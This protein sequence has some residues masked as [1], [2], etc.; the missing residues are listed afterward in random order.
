MQFKG[1]RYKQIPNCYAQQGHTSPFGEWVS[2][3]VQWSKGLCPQSGHGD[4]SINLKEKVLQTY[5]MCIRN[6]SLRD[7]PG[8]P[9]AKILHPQCR[10]LGLDPWSGNKIPHAAIKDPS[11][12]D[13]DQRF[14]MPQLR[15]GTAK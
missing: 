2:E 12:C 9:V 11:C 1:M 7:F 15:P 3:R 4:R 10:G 5:P 6:T 14:H 8:G 13:K